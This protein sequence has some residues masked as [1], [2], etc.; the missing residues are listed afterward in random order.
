[1]LA[2]ISAVSM[3]SFPTPGLAPVAPVTPRPAEATE[4]QAS[5]EMFTKMV[6]NLVN[7]AQAQQTK[8][9]DA[10]KGMLTGQNTNIHEVMLAMEQARLTMSLVVETRNKFVEAYQELNRIQM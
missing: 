8:A 10:V 5:G 9:D 3:P 2:T 6:S 1:M 7:E 4:G